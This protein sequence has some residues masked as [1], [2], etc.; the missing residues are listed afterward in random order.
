[1][2]TRSRS[3]HCAIAT[4]CKCPSFYKYNDLWP[5]LKFYKNHNNTFMYFTLFVYGKC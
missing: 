2:C 5:A 3:N 4:A 1:M